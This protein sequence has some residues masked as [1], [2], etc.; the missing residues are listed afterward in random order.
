MNEDELKKVFKEVLRDELRSGAFK[1]ELKATH[2]E[3]LNEISAQVGRWT[4]KTVGAALVAFLTYWALK[5]NG[6]SKT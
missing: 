6:W 5:M 3:W 2:K 1:D 4:M